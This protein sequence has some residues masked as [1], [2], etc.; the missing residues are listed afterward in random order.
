MSRASATLH[1]SA[2]TPTPASSGR[3]RHAIPAKAKDLAMLG[4]AVAATSVT[5][6]LRHCPE[7]SRMTFSGGCTPLLAAS[8]Y[9]LAAFSGRF[10]S[11]ARMRSLHVS[12][13][14]PCGSLGRFIE[15]A[16]AVPTS[17]TGS[18][19]ARSASGWRQALAGYCPMDVGRNP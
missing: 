17:A 4:S 6:T 9:R 3:T 19:S 18:R 7:T 8:A 1:M 12:G 13:D 14:H 5:V 15:L 2:R 16:Q 10:C 11:V